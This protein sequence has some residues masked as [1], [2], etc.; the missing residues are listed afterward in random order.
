VTEAERYLRKARESLASAKADARARRSNSAANRAY[1]AAFQAAVAAL[2]FYRVRSADTE[3]QHRF[4]SD[5]F[6]G[7]LIR[8]RKEFGSSLRSVLPE[9]FE[10]RIKADYGSNDVSKR[11]A[12]LSVGRANEVVVAVA[13]KIERSAIGETKS[14][15][16]AVMKAKQA[17]KAPEQY[18]ED[19]KKKI[20]ENYPDVD[21]KVQQRGPRDFT[22]RVYGDYAEMGDVSR[23]L[24]DT[25]IDLLNDHDV[26]IV[27]L[28]L[29]RHLPDR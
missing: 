20:T 19:V 12:T 7:K 23:S 8:R 16:E 27:V 14:S 13:K 9:L 29:E 5:E 26:W 10:V 25:T 21:F 28:A 4:V 17:S 24:G 6:S 2:I 3:W 11:D 15:Y 18:V 22:L 1:Y